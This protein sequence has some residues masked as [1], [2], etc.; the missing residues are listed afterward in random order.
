M[1]EN[2]DYRKKVTESNKRFAQEHPDLN[3]GQNNPMY[4]KHHTEEALTKIRAHAAAYKTKIVQ[5]DKNILEEI[6]VFDG[7]KD[8]EKH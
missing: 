8:A 2:E 4:G 7:I 3:K 6:Q 1:W 5:L